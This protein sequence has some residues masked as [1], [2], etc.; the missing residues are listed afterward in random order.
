MRRSVARPLV[1][2]LAA[3][4]VALTAPVA[5]AVTIPTT[6]SLILPAGP[7]QIS[8]PI[9]FKATVTP[10]PSAGAVE[11]LTGGRSLIAATVEPDGSATAVLP[12]GLWKGDHIIT[13]MFTGSDAHG[14]SISESQVLPVV[15]DRLPVSCDPDRRSQPVDQERSGSDARAR[16]AEPGRRLGRLLLAT[17]PED[18][19]EPG[20]H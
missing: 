10:A 8:A 14:P 3:L 6:T 7:V 13:A 5:S 18:G 20:R 15:D 17:K 4:I 12:Q 19:R 2:L 16:D 11:F 9:T 1:L